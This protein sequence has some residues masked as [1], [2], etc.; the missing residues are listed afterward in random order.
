MEDSSSALWVLIGTCVL[1]W[2]TVLILIRRV[3]ETEKPWAWNLLGWAVSVLAMQQSYGLYLQFTELNPPVLSFLKEILGVLVASLMLGGIVMLAPILKI[4]QRNKELLAVID[5]RNIIICQFHDRIVRT[6]R[7][8]QIAM[9]VGK[10]TNYIIEQVAEMSKMLQVFLEDLKAGV[11]LGSKFEIAL[12]T[13]IEELS[14]EGA[15]PI[16]VYVD[17]AIEDSISFDQGSELLHMLREAIH[18]SVQYS[19]AKKGKV[20]VKVKESAILFEVSDNGKGFEFDLVGAEGHGLG[21][22]AGR[23]KEIGARLKV[24]SQPNK[25]TTIVIELPRKSLSSVGN[26]GVSSPQPYN[27]KSKKVPVG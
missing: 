2:V 9:E 17:P 8:V 7:Q 19:Q 23:A 26:H 13:L 3:R 21:K 16:S 10:P 20:S 22:M 25:G 1:H 11:L 14:K 15:F 12:N 24:H 5:E 4:L 27:G 18:N 6:L